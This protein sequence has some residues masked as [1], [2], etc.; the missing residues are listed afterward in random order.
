MYP[1]PLVYMSVRVGLGIAPILLL[2]MDAEEAD[3]APLNTPGELADGV[4]A[5]LFRNT[6]S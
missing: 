3:T 6:W 4:A 5:G 2:V 1:V